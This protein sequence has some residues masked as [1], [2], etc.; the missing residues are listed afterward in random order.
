MLERRRQMIE[1]Q[2]AL[3]EQQAVYATTV[4][5]ALTSL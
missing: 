4:R 1:L 3:S 2:Q 5:L